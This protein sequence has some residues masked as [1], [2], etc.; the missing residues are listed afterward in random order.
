[1]GG[2]DLSGEWVTALTRFAE[3]LVAVTLH[4][5]LA[6]NVALDHSLLELARNCSQLKRFEFIDKTIGR[7]PHF[8][9]N[10]SKGVN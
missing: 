5:T 6:S 8:T 7:I 2:V 10:G 1:M 9:A 3:T 4:V